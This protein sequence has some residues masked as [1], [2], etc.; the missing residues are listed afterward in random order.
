[1]HVHNCLHC[2]Q[3]LFSPIVTKA[4]S[5]TKP[6]TS[7][8]TI[9]PP[10]VNP[11]STPSA[12]P[13]TPTPTPQQAQQELYQKQLLIWQLLSAQSQDE[14]ANNQEHE[15]ALAQTLQQTNKRLQIVQGELANKNNK[16]TIEQL[17][18]KV[19]V[20][21]TQQQALQVELELK[22]A[23]RIAQQA[24]STHPNVWKHYRSHTAPY[25]TIY[26]KI[27]K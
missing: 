15:A 22:Q 17:Q 7:S 14:T 8:T 9:T 24:L 3:G 4:S 11:T 27:L 26:F 2:F 16:Q 25:N 19:E 13:T 21:V 5:T 20:L 10:T 18:N 23:N 1:M 12:T 6:S